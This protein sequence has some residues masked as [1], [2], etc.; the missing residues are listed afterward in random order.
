MLTYIKTE[1]DFIKNCT[2]I[3]RKSLN[4]EVCCLIVKL[5]L[6]SGI[7]KLRLGSGTQALSGSLRL[8][9]ALNQ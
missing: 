4:E 5:R 9:Q 3:L 6:G 8:T 1:I 7:V 2:Y